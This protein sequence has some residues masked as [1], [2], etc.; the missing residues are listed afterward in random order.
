MKLSIHIHFSPELLK[1]SYVVCTDEGN[2]A[3]LVDPQQVDVPLFELLESRNKELKAVL[4]THLDEK[5]AGLI[6]TLRRMYRFDIYGADDHLDG[7]NIINVKR[8]PAFECM[9][10]T[11]GAHYLP[12]LYMD[13][14]SYNIGNFLFAGE[15]LSAGLV[16]EADKGFGKALLVQ[17]IR[18]TFREMPDSTIVLP[19]MGPPTTIRAEREANHTLLNWQDS[20][21]QLPRH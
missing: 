9:G 17:C 11:I 1:N 7:I 16:H 12:G 15:I 5:R 18:E 21:L 6:R 4:F 10:L 3:I 8:L 13:S 2:G 19:G 14:L 20:A